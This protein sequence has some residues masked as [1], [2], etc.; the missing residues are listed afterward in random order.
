M[1]Y[2]Q[3]V[4]VE[5]EG[6][7]DRLLPIIDDL[8]EGI[9]RE[10]LLLQ[11]KARAEMAENTCTFDENLVLYSTLYEMIT[12]HSSET[13]FDT[14]Y[15]TRD[16]KTIADQT[17]PAVFEKM[18][19]PEE[20]GLTYMFFA[21]RDLPGLGELRQ[22][23]LQAD[24]HHVLLDFYGMAEDM[25]DVCFCSELRERITLIADTLENPE[26]DEVLSRMQ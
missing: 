4:M 15:R 10:D 13:G 6:I 23:I 8:A 14:P 11:Q 3:K 24:D 22:R 25:D 26:H 2:I 17:L 1:R 9:R 19:K 5:Y 21:L 7:Q 16:L 20:T 12:N 18:Q